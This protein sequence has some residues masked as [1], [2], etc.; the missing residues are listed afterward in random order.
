[1]RF[2]LPA[3]LCAAL[4]WASSSA[5]VARPGRRLVSQLS[6]DFDG[7]ALSADWTVGRSNLVDSLT[8]ADGGLTLVP[9]T[10]STFGYYQNG[11]GVSITKPIE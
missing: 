4:S 9:V 2:L 5:S 6:D 11:N 8:A 10:T 7:A 3:A 1:M